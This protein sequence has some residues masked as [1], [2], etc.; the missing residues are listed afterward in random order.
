MLKK[1][2]NPS[3]GRLCYRYHGLIISS[4]SSVYEDLYRK[5]LLQFEELL[6]KKFQPEDDMEES[7]FVDS[8][9]AGD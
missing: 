5:K 7:P 8:Y 2:K 3:Y 4:D 1:Q 9:K 6:E